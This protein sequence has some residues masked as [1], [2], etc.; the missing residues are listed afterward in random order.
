MTGTPLNAKDT[1]LGHTYGQDSLDKI[2]FFGATPI[3]K[4]T[5]SDQAAVATTAAA[6]TASVFGF[7][8]AAQA[9]AVVT[10]LNEVRATLVAYG[11]IKGSS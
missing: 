8:T 4:R 2:S 6:S 1:S 3:V 10:L 9:D 7:T 5:G 11:L